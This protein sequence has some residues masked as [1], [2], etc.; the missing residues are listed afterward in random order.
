MMSLDDP[1]VAAEM[2]KSGSFFAPGALSKVSPPSSNAPNSTASASG[3]GLTPF[4]GPNFKWLSSS[5][6]SSAGLLTPGL[7]LGSSL[8]L[9]NISAAATTSSGSGLTPFLGSGFLDGHINIGG[10]GV[11]PGRESNIAELKEFWKQFMR[12]PGEKTPGIGILEH[13]LHS[14]GSHTGSET[15]RPRHSLVK[16]AS[17]PDL[18]T[19]G[20]TNLNNNNNSQVAGA[21]YYMSDR[22]DLRSYEQAVLARKA[23][24]LTLI[25]KRRGTLPQ[26]HGEMQ[27]KAAT[28]NNYNRNLKPNGILPGHVVVDGSPSPSASST[29]SAS[30]TGSLSTHTHKAGRERP[31]FKRLAS[32]TLGPFESKSAKVS[33]R[34]V[35]TGEDSEDGGR[36]D[37]EW[38]DMHEPV[39]NHDTR[40]I[41]RKQSCGESVNTSTRDPTRGL[42]VPEIVA[43]S[44]A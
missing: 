16:M 39:T 4:L 13:G 8:G 29:N 12:T 25:P 34:N 24:Q 42:H 23:P 18:K 11:T 15:S 2:N 9:G 3:T 7:G 5:L 40:P 20:G 31:S 19:P 41:S 10:T 17:Y 6:N 36:D 33:H 35:N 37:A 14:D 30:D 28:D 32:Q 27:V 22:E 1:V 44:H 43:L 21:S 38:F 26:T